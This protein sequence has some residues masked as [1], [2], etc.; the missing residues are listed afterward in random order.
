MRR[1]ELTRQIGALGENVQVN[2]EDSRKGMPFPRGNNQPHCG[3][4]LPP[5]RPRPRSSPRRRRPRGARWT[6]SKLKST[7][8][9]PGKPTLL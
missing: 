4:P 3:M 8:T 5:S 7:T 2:E 6:V 1:E 9:T